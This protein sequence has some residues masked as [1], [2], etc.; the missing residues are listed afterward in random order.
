MINQNTGSYPY[1]ENDLKRE[2]AYDATGDPVYIGK[3]APGSLTSAAAWQIQKRTYN[4]ARGC[5]E[6][7]FASG[8]N[9]YEHVWDDRAGYVY[10]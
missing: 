5:T 10:S 9:E 3:A 1:D 4:A 8:D 7:A 2:Y 6:I